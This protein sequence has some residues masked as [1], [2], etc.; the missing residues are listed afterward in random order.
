MGCTRSNLVSTEIDRAP[1]PLVQAKTRP[2]MSPNEL[3]KRHSG[4]DSTNFSQAELDII[5][6]TWNMLGDEEVFF[7]SV[8]VRY[9]ITKKIEDKIKLY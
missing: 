7:T 6:S 4:V 9:I 5:R 2:T 1:T 3:V 8:M